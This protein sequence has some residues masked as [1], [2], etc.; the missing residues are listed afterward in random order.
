MIRERKGHEARV[1]KMLEAGRRRKI[2]RLIIE[3]EEQIWELRA[4]ISFVDPEKWIR[5]R[6]GLS[7]E[8]SRA[9]RAGVEKIRER[10]TGITEESRK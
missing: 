6:E 9:L 3:I 5:G 8:Q 1:G 4:D 10:L 2:E 7:A